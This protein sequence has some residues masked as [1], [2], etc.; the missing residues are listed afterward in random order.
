[1]ERVVRNTHDD[2]CENCEQ[3]R[4]SERQRAARIIDEQ[5]RLANEWRYNIEL[6]K[7]VIL[8]GAEVEKPYADDY[9]AKIYSMAD[10]NAAVRKANERAVAWVEHWNNTPISQYDCDVDLRIKD[11]DALLQHIL[12]N[13]EVPK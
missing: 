8:D 10:L 13:D 9:N 3:V 2:G 5:L 4:A 12:N 1:M 11:Y 6:T 7:Q